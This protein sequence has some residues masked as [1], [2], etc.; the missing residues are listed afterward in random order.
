MGALTSRQNAGVEEVDVPANSVYRYPPKSG[1]YFANHFI[2][3]GE[4]FDS[5]HPEGYLFGENSD[6]NF[7]GNRPVLFPYAAPPPQE[8]VKTLRSLINI[9]KDTLRLVKCSEEVKTPGEEVSK[10]KVHYNVEF[11]FDTDARVAITIYYQAS[12]EFHNGV[13]SYVPRDSSLQSETVHYK[14]GVCQQFC[15]PSHTVDPSEWT[16]EELG[17]DLDREVFPMVVHAV[18]DEGDEHA[19]HSHVLLATFEKHA[20]GTFCVKP[21]KQKQV[22]DG[23]SYLLQEIY[24][25]E[26]KYNTQDSKVAEDEVSDNSAECVVCLSDVRD[27]LILPC[28][29][30]CLCNTCADTLRYQANNCPI[31][32]LPFRALLQIRAMRKKLGP[33]SPTGFNPII[34]SQ[35]S[36]SEEHSSSENIPPGYE[37]VSLLEA[38]NGPL[39]PSPGAVRLRALG[40]AAPPGTGPLP[41]YGSD[42]RLPPLRALSPL[43]RLSDCAP[44]GLKLKKSI[45]K[46]ISQNSSVL[47]EEEDEKSGTESELRGTRRKSPARLEEEC[48]VTPESENLTLSSSGAI[49]QSS[50]TGTPL[51][52]TI[53]SPEEPVSSSL[54]QSVMSMASS[55]SQHSQLSTDTVSSMSGSYVAPGTEEEGDTL[56][57]PA[58]ATASDG[59]S[60]P[61]ES[62]DINFVSIS[63]EEHD[64]E[65]NAV[66]EDE[67]A[68][69]TQDDGRRTGAF[70]GLRCDNNNDLGIAHVKAL[71]NKLCSEARLPGPEAAN[72][73]VR[74]L[75]SRRRPWERLPCQGSARGGACTPPPRTEGPGHRHLH[76][77]A[78]AELTIFE[79][80]DD[81]LVFPSLSPVTVEGR[82]GHS[83]EHGGGGG[84][85]SCVTS[86]PPPVS[87]LLSPSTNGDRLGSPSCPTCV[88]VG[89]DRVTPKRGSW[90]TATGGRWQEGAHG[91]RTSGSSGILGARAG[92]L[93]GGLALPVCWHVPVPWDV[94]TGALAVMALPLPGPPHPLSPPGQHAS[95]TRWLVPRD[96]GGVAGT[97]SPQSPAPRGIARL[98]S[99]S[100][101][102]LRAWGSGLCP[103]S[104]TSAKSVTPATLSCSVCPSHFVAGAGRGWGSCPPSLHPHPSI[105]IPPSLGWQ[106]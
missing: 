43:E 103:L 7:L 6:L 9:R 17:F 12:E 63:A 86:Q 77:W 69:P 71:D 88:P 14:R 16:E 8:P 22:V 53:S 2:M 51:S 20:D 31:C 104:G 76:P 29:H 102:P 66:L 18:V 74:L 56:P 48:G 57:S 32:R 10:A 4:K 24:G 1:S 91:L 61:V 65:G 42:G 93:R 40:D 99:L 101:A 55:Q 79:R 23:V 54:A 21:L 87:T 62:L 70:L 49:D 52:S 5:T 39:T 59:E 3:G 100:S 89:R 72:T 73:D 30:L 34:A 94:P 81:N 35:T 96:G 97:R 67:D 58:A 106:R 13:A 68:S 92:D 80:K 33:L 47:P 84:G 26:N 28:R 78:V 37:V 45:S 11:T 95:S 36:D 83:W 60:T 90:G 44:P 46:S 50:C 25:I 15:V 105:P 98:T 41:P 27:T 64:A 75:R 38:L 19:G 85:E 82:G